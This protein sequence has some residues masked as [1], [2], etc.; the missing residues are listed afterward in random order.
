MD[1][2]YSIDREG[3]LRSLSQAIARGTPKV[4]QRSLQENAFQQTGRDERGERGTRAGHS[5]APVD[6]RARCEHCD[7]LLPAKCH[8]LRK[9]CSARCL[10]LSETRLIQAATLEKKKGRTCAA[11]GGDIPIARQLG[12]KFCSVYCA[13]KVGRGLSEKKACHH[14][15]RMFRRHRREQA[16]CSNACRLAAAHKAQ[17]AACDWCGVLYRRRRKVQKFCCGSCSSKAKCENWGFHIDTPLTAAR[18]DGLF[19][20]NSQSSR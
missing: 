6:L 18:L 7:K 12:S 17:W 10:K 1:D 19:R 16:F 5:G 9:Y 20:T 3:L 15:G 2:R 4:L 13:H 14:C 11:C 8:G